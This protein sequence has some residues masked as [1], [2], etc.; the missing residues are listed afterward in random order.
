MNYYQN[1]NSK[2]RLFDPKNLN[3]A[4]IDIQLPKDNMKDISEKIQKLYHEKI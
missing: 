2:M 4:L 1:N 3:D